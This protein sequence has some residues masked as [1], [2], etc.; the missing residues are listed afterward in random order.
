MVKAI[1]GDENRV[2]P[3]S[4]LLQGEYGYRDVFAS[5]PCRLNREGVAEVI[6]LHL[7]AEEKAKFD[8]SVKSMGENFARAMGM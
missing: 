1:Y 5:V 6:E 2:L 7:T 8:A 4:T 3:V